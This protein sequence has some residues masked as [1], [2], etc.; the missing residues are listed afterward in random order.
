MPQRAVSIQRRRVAG[1]HRA[2]ALDD[3]VRVG[4]LH[5]PLDVLVDHQDALAA[6]LEPLQAGD[7]FFERH[8]RFA[9]IDALRASELQGFCTDQS[10]D[11]VL[12]A[13]GGY[14]LTRILDRFDFDAIRQANRP[15]CGYSDFTAFNLAYLARAGGVSL[16]GP[17]AMDFGASHPHPL[18]CAGFLEVLQARADEAACEFA[19]DADGPDCAVAG[20][21]WGGNLALVC[22]LLGTPCF[23]T[24][25]QWRGSIAFLEDVNE[26]AYKVERMLLQLVQAGVLDRRRAV[27]L[28]AFDPVPPQPKDNGFTL[29]DAVDTLRQ[30]L[31]M[32][33]ITGLPL[34]HVAHKLTLPV[35]ATVSLRVAGGGATLRWGGAL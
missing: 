20:L 1:P 30:R 29:A 14:G 16:H 35:G 25:A 10:L 24:P 9:G 34:G 7:S 26:P 17:S 22:A 31:P 3:G 12:A 23:P 5:Q 21:L 4:Q 11:L 6:V 32:P 19:F 18:T 33:I 8:L 28:G 13:R 2:P 15:I 27:L